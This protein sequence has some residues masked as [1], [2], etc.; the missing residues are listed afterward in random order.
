M[1]KILKDSKTTMQENTEDGKF[2]YLKYEEKHI[3]HNSV[4]FVGT[5]VLLN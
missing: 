5:K 2:N 1:S 4:F 3:D